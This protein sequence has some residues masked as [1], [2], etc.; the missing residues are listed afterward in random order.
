[1]SSGD[2]DRKFETTDEGIY[3]ET[4][5]FYSFDPNQGEL[6]LDHHRFESVDPHELPDMV[7]QAYAENRNVF[8]T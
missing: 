6:N 4:G 7:D 8:K 1:M 3:T 2:T 5:E